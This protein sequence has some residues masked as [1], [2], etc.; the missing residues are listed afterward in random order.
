MICST[1]RCFSIGVAAA[2]AA[3]S[4]LGA[5]GV[6]DLVAG[7]HQWLWSLPDEP[8]FNGSFLITS[9]PT[10]LQ[11]VGFPDGDV[12]WHQHVTMVSPIHFVA[13]GHY[14]PTGSQN[15]R[16]VNP[17]GGYFSA[18]IA[19]QV[20]IF[21]NGE[22]TDLMLGTLTDPIDPEWGFSPYPVLNLATQGD[23]VGKTLLVVGKAGRA[24][25]A[26]IG[27]FE[28]YENS[29]GFDATQF[30]YFDY[31]D[32]GGPQDVYFESGDSGSPSFVVENGV[33]VLV[34]VHSDMQ[35][36]LGFMRNFDSFVPEYMNELDALME[37]EGYHLTRF[38]PEEASMS[39]A[40]AGVG[41]TRR[42]K[43]GSVTVAINNPGTTAAHNMAVGLAFS[44]APISVSGAGWVCEELAAGIWSCRRGGVEGG[45]VETLTAEWTALPMAGEVTVDVTREWDGATPVM[46]SELVALLPSYGE[47]SMGLAKPGFEEDEDRD[48][49]VN[50]LEYAFGGDGAVAVMSGTAGQMLR[51]MAGA[52]GVVR[53]PQ[54]TDA[55]ERGL[56]YLVEYSD[57]LVTWSAVVPAGVTV[58]VADY[59]PVVEGFEEARVSGLAASS[60]FLR[61]RVVLAE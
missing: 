47:W 49:I 60:G 40:V 12:E 52:D 55:V 1:C 59:A 17:A 36:R 25:N 56:S 19:E 61:V 57:D 7:R 50:L 22:A 54:R 35:S 24:G 28:R 20:V 10:M 3:A 46:T 45:A 42:G 6:R 32:V 31:P 2:L 8:V 18:G 53:F 29:P 9:D 30:C 16:F 43:A 48:G 34:G 38:Y 58:G 27:G 33:P 44:A 41:T 11:G 51:P 23:Y 21:S 14:M 4:E 26:V 13:A 39:A 5:L 15:I 37:L